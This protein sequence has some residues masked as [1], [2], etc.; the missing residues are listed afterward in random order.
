MAIFSGKTTAQD[1]TCLHIKVRLSWVWRDRERKYR[2]YNHSPS[3]KCTDIVMANCCLSGSLHR[4]GELCL[5]SSLNPSIT[6][7][8]V[9]LE[10]SFHA[11]TWCWDV[12]LYLWLSFSTL[13]E[14]MLLAAENFNR[15]KSYWLVWKRSNKAANAVLCFLRWF[16]AEQKMFQ[17]FSMTPSTSMGSHSSGE[18]A[19][20]SMFS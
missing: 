4:P 17:A 12:A 13:H 6:Q 8:S 2:R 19:L 18:P 14:V 10:F 1:Y 7:F 9:Y 20:C 11:K 15:I 16:L 3:L 5:S